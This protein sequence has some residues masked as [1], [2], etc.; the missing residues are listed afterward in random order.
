MGPV[1]PLALEE[2]D[3]ES[4][5]LTHLVTQRD[6]IVNAKNALQQTVRELDVVARE[7]FTATFES[8]RANFQ[9]VFQTLFGGGNA[10][11][12]LVES[13]V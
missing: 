11:L 10:E 3:E 2:H 6:D 5:R 9:Q 13:V 8:A 7:K 1:N 4:K 12:Q